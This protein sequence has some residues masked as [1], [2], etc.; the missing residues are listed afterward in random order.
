MTGPLELT[1]RP[2]AVRRGLRIGAWLLGASTACACQHSQP[3]APPT[4]KEPEHPP[5]LHEL[6]PLKDKTVSSF[7]MSSDLSET[8]LLVLE[9]FRPR[10]ELAELTIAGSTTRL[11]VDEQRITL[12][13]GGTLLQTPLRVGATFM[14]SFGTTTITHVNATVELPIG[15]LKHC[16]TTVEEATR[17]PKRSESTYCPGIGL[18]HL[19][20]ESFGS[21][22]AGRVETR[23]TDHGP[24]YDVR[25]QP[26]W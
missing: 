22:D 6:L 21:Q 8:G 2:K 15:T 20:V 4:E 24:R 1:K 23:L 14:G 5:T 16:L 26:D 25:E 10:E 12:A 3:N 18:A 11:L 17:P 13:T 7:E 19:V 9:I